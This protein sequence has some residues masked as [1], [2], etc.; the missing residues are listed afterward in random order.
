MRRSEKCDTA[1]IQPK[2]FESLSLMCP[3]DRLVLDVS[4][5]RFGLKP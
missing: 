5:A 1:E 4:I 3:D 2:E